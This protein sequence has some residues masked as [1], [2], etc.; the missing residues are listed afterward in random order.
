[1]GWGTTAPSFPSGSSWL[2]I[3]SSNTTMNMYSV[4][5]QIHMARMATNQVCIRFKLSTST[6]ET[7][8]YKPPDYMD[9]RVTINGSASTKTYDW[10]ANQ[11][12]VANKTVY[13]TG[14]LGE[15]DSTNATKAYVYAG[16]HD[17][18][19]AAFSHKTY[20][21]GS[22]AGPAY[23][24][25]YTI[26][27]KANGASGADQT[28]SKTYGH[29]ETLKGASTYSRTGY[30]MSGWNTAADG[31]GT[32]YAAGASYSANANV[33]LYAEWTP[34]ESQILSLSSSAQT[35]GE[36]A[37]QMDRKVS[38]YY[39][40]AVFSSG[41][42]TLYTSS[43]F[44]TALTVSVPRTWFNS[45]P[46][47]ASI[48][49]T[50]TVKTYTDSSCTTQMGSAVTGTV[51]VTADADMK[52]TVASGWATLAAYNT[53]AVSG[54]TGYIKGYSMVQATFD[55]TKVTHA[56]N[57]TTASF[58]V[59]CQGETDSTSPYRTG[60][61]TSAGTVNVVCKVTDSRGRSA[62]QTLSVSV[63][64]YAGPGVTNTGIWR[65][66]S[67][68]T[69]DEEGTYI[70]VLATATCT[71]LNNQ[72]SATMT[73]AT[74]PAGGSWSTEKSLTSGTVKKLSGYDPDTNYTVRV[75]VTDALGN[76]STYS[77]QIPRR[78]WAMKFRANGSGVAFG[79]APSADNLF[80]L[81]DAM[82][83]KGKGFIDLIYPVGAIY[84]STVA[85]S[86]ATLFG[87]GTWERITGK[88]LLSATDGGSSG[89]SQ[90]AGNTGGAAT[91]K[92]T[93]GNHTLALG[94]LPAHQHGTN[95]DTHT[96]FV[97]ARGGDTH[98]VERKGF[99]TGST[100]YAYANTLS[101]D[102][103]LSRLGLTGST[104]GGLAH[105][106]GDTGSE[107]SLPP[108]LSVYMWKRTA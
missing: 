30:A 5:I 98:A 35:Q 82:A 22:K 92:H 65:S 45:F 20:A 49:V 93:T 78:A 21:S 86:P 26:T 15:D 79:K 46:N 52:P 69:A 76:T 28:Q 75:T 54:L 104:G 2:H 108:Y 64:D 59:T 27:Y 67:S 74:Q 51:T 1:M 102:G 25:K 11:P 33:T 62:S 24:T 97:L 77:Q 96:T 8:T 85:T 58:S 73:V 48:T 57:A 29:S 81:D 36:I 99:Q 44:A 56:N 106:H 16:A 42:T 12:W 68:G 63:M 88:F 71:S 83:V 9:F 40:K 19:G 38:T 95:S 50:V 91:H 37:L 23:L 105:N 47:N 89:A 53:G 60:I 87:F 90:A 101:T 32:H 100:N 17:V 4:G 84:I 66:N 10:A 3:A 80:E 94:E 61:L 34:M 14:T 55:G 13:W 43:A 107:S 18:G 41:G 103:N 70:R 72:N 39:H 31:S 7:S 6:G